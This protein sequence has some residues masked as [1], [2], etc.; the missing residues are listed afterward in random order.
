ME[1]DVLLDKFKKKGLWWGIQKRK[2]KV[3]RTNG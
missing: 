3:K 1:V 2:S